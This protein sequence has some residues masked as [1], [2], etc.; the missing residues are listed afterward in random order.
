MKIANQYSI[1][2]FVLFLLSMSSFAQA[3]AYCYNTTTGITNNNIGVNGPINASI[4]SINWSGAANSMTAGY[5][6]SAWST[7]G[8]AGTLFSCNTSGTVFHSSAW[9]KSAVASIPNMTYTLNGTTYKV[10][11]TLLP[12]IGYIVAAADTNLALIPI[13]DTPSR[14]YVNTLYP[15][16]GVRYFIQFVSTG[17][18]ISGNYIIPAQD[19]AYIELRDS[20]AT[21]D[22]PYTKQTTLKLNAI[23]ITF[24]VSSCSINTSNLYIP[25]AKINPN[26]LVNNGDSSV[27]T[28][29]SISLYCP[30]SV[31]TYLTFTD[32]NNIANTSNLLSLDSNSLARGI[33][34]QIKYNNALI[35][36]GPDSANQG[37]TNQFL[38]QNAM[39][40]SQTISFSALVT[41]TGPI[42]PGNFSAKATFTFSYQ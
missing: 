39:L 17:T 20:S 25:L 9:V 40:G 30:S 21:T 22:S 12:G 6:Q 14:L 33:A 4:S 10:F 8:T 16:Q 1:Y 31:N 27:S 5:S 29:F 28:P 42:A 13:T 36:F 41:K 2:I 24:K 26:S 3:D 34:M 19:I 11:P 32:A 18:P 23:P 15:N 7:Q 38:V 35:S 37:N